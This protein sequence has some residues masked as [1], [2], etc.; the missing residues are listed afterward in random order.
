M[1]IIQKVEN[2]FN[3][4][5]ALSLKV[6]QRIKL[7]RKVLLISSCFGDFVVGTLILRQFLISKKATGVSDGFSYDVV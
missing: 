7:N 6:S 2:M 4:T 3:A 5:M 1:E